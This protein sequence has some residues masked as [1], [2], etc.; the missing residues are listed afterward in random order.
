M[1][2]II[3]AHLPPAPAT[4]LTEAGHRSLHVGEVGPLDASDRQVWLA[5]LERGCAIVTKDADFLGLENGP[6]QVPVL[7]LRIGNCGNARLMALVLAHVETVA[8]AFTASETL[9][10]IR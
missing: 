6:R 8:A 1:N 7:W 4:R 3:D 2:F 9:V 10:E 5:A